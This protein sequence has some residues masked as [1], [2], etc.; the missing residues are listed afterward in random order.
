M[1]IAKNSGGRDLAGSRPPLLAR[2]DLSP[3]CSHASL[4]SG[5]QLQQPPA[6]PQQGAG[7]HGAGQQT[8]TGTCLQTTTGTHRV[9]V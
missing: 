2:P 5:D 6:S 1:L 3:D 9:T 4:T 7:Q 8:V